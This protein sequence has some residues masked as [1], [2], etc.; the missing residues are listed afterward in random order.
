[1]AR[2]NESLQRT[3]TM[4]QTMQ[5]LIL[6]AFAIVF[7]V[8]LTD[9]ASAQGSVALYCLN[10]TG[11]QATNNLWLPCSSTN[12]LQVSSS[13]GGGGVVTQPTASLL[14]ATVVGTGT[15]AVQI[16]PSSASAAGLSPSS[17]SAL[18]A[19]QTIKGSAGNL[20]AF[21]VSAD[22]T[23][24]S[25]PWWVMIFNATSLPADGAVTP[26]KCYAVAAGVPSVSYGW[27]T[28]VQF[29]NGI[30]IGASTTGCFTKTASAHAF[31]SGDA[32]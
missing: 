14:N 21:E 26:A 22:S 10:P 28:P 2:I 11:S 1:M 6:A 29:S 17:T 13:G 24:S 15:F 31:I 30:V 19:S 27:N 4:N 25:A 5:R 7:A 12:P 23:L 32:Q 16:S 3:H 18:A 9:R 8:A 20:Y